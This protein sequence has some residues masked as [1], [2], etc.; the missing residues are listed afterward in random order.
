[1]PAIPANA[2]SLYPRA[3]GSADF[4]PVTTVNGQPIDDYEFPPRQQQQQP[5]GSGAGASSSRSGYTNNALY[6]TGPPGAVPASYNGDL[7]RA[8]WDSSA[9]PNDGRRPS[10]DA[11]SM[12]AHASSVSSP[13]SSTLGLG[14]GGLIPRAGGSSSS[15]A[16]GSGATAG[17]NNN[18]LM[19]FQSPDPLSPFFRSVQERNLVGNISSFDPTTSSSFSFNNLS[20][21]S[22]SPAAS[23]SSA[24]SHY[25]MVSPASYDASTIPAV[26]QHQHHQNNFTASSPVLS[27]ASSSDFG[28]TPE[29]VAYR[30]NSYPHLLFSSSPSSSTSC[31]S[32]SQPLTIDPPAPIAPQGVDLRRPSVDLLSLA[33]KTGNKPDSEVEWLAPPSMDV[34][35]PFSSYEEESFAWS[36]A[37]S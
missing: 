21:F 22:S 27:N 37:Y 17:P 11:N 29:G 20:P 10:W 19:L 2:R 36:A 24:S 18:G 8:S 32:S 30:K 34:V 4:Y 1:M 3:P 9:G 33:E 6:A 5:F 13:A 31:S 16:G 25:S 15:T 26:A 28:I 12:G 7:R 23:S 14:L 35:R